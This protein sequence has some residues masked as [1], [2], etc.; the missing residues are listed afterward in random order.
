MKTQQTEDVMKLPSGYKI[1]Q[2]L[3][4]LYR[5]AHKSLTNIH[6]AFNWTY[7]TTTGSITPEGALQNAINT[8]S[9]FRDIYNDCDKNN[10][11][12]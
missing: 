2:D 1:I 4:D 7:I 8:N 12:G 9:L 10:L 6:G 3:K 5:V 11:L